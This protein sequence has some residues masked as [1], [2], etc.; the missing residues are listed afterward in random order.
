[1]YSTRQ[2]IEI[3]DLVHFY[4]KP[5]KQYLVVSFIFPSGCFMGVQLLRLYKN[6]RPRFR[7]LKEV[8]DKNMENLIIEGR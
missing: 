4:H 7:F 1:M 2:R 5:K 3:G 8:V 6:W